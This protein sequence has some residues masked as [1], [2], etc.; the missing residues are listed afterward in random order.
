MPEPVSMTLGICWLGC[1]GL[2]GLVRG[3]SA[4]SREAQVVREAASVM[5]E[6]VERSE[7]FFGRK[8][9][10]ISQL[11]ALANECAEDGWDGGESLPVEPMAVFVAGQFV[12][13]LPESGPIPE[14]APDPDGSISLDWI[15]SGHRLFSL[16]IGGSGRLAYA[17]LDGRT[18]A[19]GLPVS[20]QPA[21]RRECWKA[22]GLS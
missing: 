12:R 10:A 18:R 14:F 2:Q 8:S 21:S 20:T 22:S 7:A 9:A 11:H 13:A 5:A 15:Q 6:S 19:A 17:W 16:S 4:V 1:A 3:D